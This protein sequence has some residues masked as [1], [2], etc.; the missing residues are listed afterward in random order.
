MQRTRRNIKTLYRGADILIFDE[1]TA[2]LTP[3][4]IKEL[5]QIMKNLVNEGKSIILITHK[6]KEIMGFVTV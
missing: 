6:L 5:M 4:E 3:H 2:V 1:P